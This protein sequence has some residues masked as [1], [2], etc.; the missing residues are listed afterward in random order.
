MLADHRYSSVQTTSTQSRPKEVAVFCGV[1]R[2]RHGINDRRA[3]Y[4]KFN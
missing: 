2:F 1:S 3:Q 4:Q